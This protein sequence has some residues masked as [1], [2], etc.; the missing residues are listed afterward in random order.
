MAGIRVHIRQDGIADHPIDQGSLAGAGRPLIHAPLPDHVRGDT[1]IRDGAVGEARIGEGTPTAVLSGNVSLP[2]VE[3]EDLSSGPRNGGRGGGELPLVHVPD[4]HGHT[5]DA[6]RLNAGHPVKIG[7]HQQRM[8][9]LQRSEVMSVGVAVALR[10]EDGGVRRVHGAIEVLIQ[11]VVVQRVDRLTGVDA[12]GVV[13]DQSIVHGS[14]LDA[15]HRHVIAARQQGQFFISQ[16]GDLT[17]EGK[18]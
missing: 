5:Q 3:I 12:A 2:P 17:L 13:P 4:R 7:I 11:D 9:S 8:I 16:C 14:G 1:G 10:I 6:D 18:E 15:G